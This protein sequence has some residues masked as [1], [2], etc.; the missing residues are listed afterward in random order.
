MNSYQNY[1]F[2]NFIKDENNEFCYL[3]A[4]EVA[5]NPRENNNPLLIYGDISTGKTHLLKAICNYIKHNSPEVK[6]LYSTVEIFTNDLINS[7]R[8]DKMNAFRMSYRQI[9]VLLLDDIQFIEGKEITQEELFHTINT[10]Y[11]LGKQII[12]TSDRRPQNI[13]TLTKRL[14]S[15]LESGLVCEIK[16]INSKIFI[17]NFIQNQIISLTKDL[18][19]LNSLK[20]NV[21]LFYELENS[22]TRR[23]KAILD[24]IIEY[25]K[26]CNKPITSEI[27]KTLI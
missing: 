21:D 11:D 27:I 14:I 13:P 1:T 7:I 15:R 18:T 6:V 3:M 20:E 26:I 16:S 17:Q 25:S 9:D 23:L 2:E 10:L 8:N 12:L 22:D 24:K 5:K 4:Q 19:T